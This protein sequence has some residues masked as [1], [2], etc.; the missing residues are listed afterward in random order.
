MDKPDREVWQVRADRAAEVHVP[1]LPEPP[2]EDTEV[3]YTAGI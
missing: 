1:G 3:P 2:E